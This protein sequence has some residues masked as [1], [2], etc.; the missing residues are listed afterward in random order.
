M[1][2][3]TSPT[4]IL[5]ATEKQEGGGKNTNQCVPSPFLRPCCSCSCYSPW[6]LPPPHAPSRRSMHFS[7]SSLGRREMA[8]SPRPGA[9]RKIAASG[10]ASFAMEMGPSL[11]S[12]WHLKDLKGSSRHLSP[13]SQA[14]C[15]STFRTTPSPEAFQWSSCPPAASSPLT[16]ASTG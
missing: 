6:S 3:S 5:Q 12:P 2:N 1:I 9:M 4:C 8:P 13:T 14:C 11:R 15:M 7:S 16:S 10:K